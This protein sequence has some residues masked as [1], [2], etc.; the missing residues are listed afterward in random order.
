MS[1]RLLGI[2]VD[3]LD[4]RRIARIA[5]DPKRSRALARRILSAQEQ[6]WME[7]LLYSDL[8]AGSRFLALRWAAKE[9]VFK[10]CFPQVYL[11]W[12]DVQVVKDPSPKPHL[13]F[14]NPDHGHLH[15]HLSISHDGDFMVA[16]VVVETE[17][18][19]QVVKP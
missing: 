14:V 9:A 1:R 12:K 11:E 16:M 13:K 8:A 5:S 19:D 15:A 3:L 2:G 6:A 7:P 4:T 18:Q 17:T 10:A